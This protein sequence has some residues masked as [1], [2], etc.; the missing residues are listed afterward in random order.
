MFGPIGFVVPS[1]API[2]HWPEKNES[3]RKLAG[4]CCFSIFGFQ[5]VD[6]VKEVVLEG[7]A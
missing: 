5:S 4:S 1:G 2:Q 7:S 3:G 6:R